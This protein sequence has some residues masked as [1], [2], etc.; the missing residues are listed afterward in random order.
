MIMWLY[1]SANVPINKNI[2]V[3]ILLSTRQSVVLKHLISCLAKD[4]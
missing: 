4:L 2:F 3:V 1:E